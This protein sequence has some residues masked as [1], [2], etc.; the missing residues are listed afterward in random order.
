ML[1]HF[2]A[3]LSA[4]AARMGSAFGVG[5]RPSVLF[6]S[7]NTRCVLSLLCQPDSARHLQNGSWTE[8]RVEPRSPKLE[9]TSYEVKK[10]ALT[11]NQRE[12]DGAQTYGTWENRIGS[13][14]GRIELHA[15]PINKRAAK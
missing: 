1:G 2:E 14:A 8:P 5:Q 7:G 12:L 11:Q 10:S 9:T 4:A 6:V 3:I 13:Q 15:D